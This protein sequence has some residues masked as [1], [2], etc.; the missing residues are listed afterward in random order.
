[1]LRETGIFLAGLNFAFGVA[2]AIDGN[3]ILIA[4][5]CAFVA[6]AFTLPPRELAD[7]KQAVGRDIA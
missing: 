3:P 1:M 7:A 6:I 5:F 4:N 2:L